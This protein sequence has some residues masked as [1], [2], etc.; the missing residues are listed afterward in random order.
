MDD[1]G[2]LHV[3]GRCKDVIRV[4]CTQV[5]PAELEDLLLQH[6]DVAEAAVIAVKDHDLL[7]S[8]RKHLSF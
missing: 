1:K 8:S 3:C 4:Y 6:E 2:L 7:L 5:D